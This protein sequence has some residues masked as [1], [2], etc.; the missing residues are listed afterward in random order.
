MKPAKGDICLIFKK[1]G[2]VDI[3]KYINIRKYINIFQIQKYK[4]SKKI[5][6]KYLNKSSS[7]E[8]LPRKSNNK[9]NIC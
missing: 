9:S 2:K 7:N 1:I 4:Q 5:T 3:H 8:A 6:R